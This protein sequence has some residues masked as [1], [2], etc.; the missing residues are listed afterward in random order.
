MKKIILL[1][2]LIALP[3]FAQKEYTYNFKN[4]DSLDAYIERY[5]LPFHS[6]DIYITKDF[7][8]SFRPYSESKFLSSPRIYVFNEE[9][10]FLESINNITS[11]K[12]LA[13]FKK[14]RKRPEKNEP[15]LDFWT[16]KIVHYKT[17]NDYDDP[18]NYDYTF[19]VNWSVIEY[20]QTQQ[21][22]DIWSEWYNVLIRQKAKGENIQIILFN[23][24]L[25]ERW[26]LSPYMRKFVLENVNRSWGG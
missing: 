15:S 20:E 18:K 8:N 11:E 12:K 14:L 10:Q 2:Y 22:V 26:E 3:I 7:E 21:V 13:N 6:E 9:G 23:T 4:S 24:N 16:S 17:G 25:Q 5:E 1:F 19:V